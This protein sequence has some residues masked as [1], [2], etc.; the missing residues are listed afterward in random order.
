MTSAPNSPG[1][2]PTSSSQS[3]K[4]VR[5]TILPGSMLPLN[6]G[7][8]LQRQLLEEKVFEFLKA[9]NR[10]IGGYQVP[11][12]N[13]HLY[14]YSRT[15]QVHHYDNY[16]G[17]SFTKDEVLKAINIKSSS[18][19]SDNVVFAPENLKHWSKAKAWYTSG[20]KTHNDLFGEM[21]TA[22]FKNGLAERR[23]RHG[24]GSSSGKGR[25]R[26][27]P[28]TRSSSGSDAPSRKHRRSTSASSDESEPEEKS[29]KKRSS[30]SKKRAPKSFT[31]DTLDV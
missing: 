9:W 25:A 2:V 14:R 6:A 24:N 19:S 30:S 26:V 5:C 13:S 27:R 23:A 21:T 15:D 11:K 12:G 8:L 3:P 4:T 20:G 31:S 28:H 1:L 10:P 16:V 7:T 18:S 17:T 22:K 29:E